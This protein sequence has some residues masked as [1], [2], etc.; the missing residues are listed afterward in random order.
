MN[1][2]KSSGTLKLAVV[3]KEMEKLPFVVTPDSSFLN[4]IELHEKNF[5]IRLIVSNKLCTT[6][7][8]YYFNDG[9]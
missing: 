7:T 9:R 6:K 1:S 4:Q 5:T 3:K 2:L 8:K